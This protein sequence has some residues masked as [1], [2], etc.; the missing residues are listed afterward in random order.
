MAS[1]NWNVL[2]KELTLGLLV[3]YEGWRMT[4]GTWELF[5]FK[6]GRDRLQ[7]YQGTEKIATA[8]VIYPFVGIVLGTPE[9][10][11]FNW[12][13]TITV[14]GALTTLIVGPLALRIRIQRRFQQRQQGGTT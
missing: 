8:V 10:S 13:V 14:L 6:R 11:I 9:L 1:L 12:H 5:Q 3:M 7:L 2:V 4:Y